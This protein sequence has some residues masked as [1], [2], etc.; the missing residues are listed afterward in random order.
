MERAGLI[1]RLSVLWD[2]YLDCC[3]P[4]YGI[5]GG[6]VLAWL[7]LLS[8]STVFSRAA[9]SALGAWRGWMLIAL[10]V[11]LL[12]VSIVAP[13]IEGQGRIVAVLGA[14]GA[15][16]TLGTL[17]H[18]RSWFRRWGRLWR[19]HSQR[20]GWRACSSGGHTC[21]RAW[22]GAGAWA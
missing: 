19:S 17:C 9:E 2:D 14:S 22:Y 12:V 4:R 15:G 3:D 6:L 21:A 1:H 10:F 7:F 20:S 8:F 13:V 18:R 16:V 11:L 5:G